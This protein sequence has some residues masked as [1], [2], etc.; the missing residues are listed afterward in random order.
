MVWYSHL[1]KNFPQFVVIL[2]ALK[3]C[4]ELTLHNNG[5]LANEHSSMD[6]LLKKSI[7]LWEKQTCS[8]DLLSGDG[9][10]KV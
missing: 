8:L 3:W 2:S 4:S 1:F 7:H 5:A 10:G 6:V 9:D